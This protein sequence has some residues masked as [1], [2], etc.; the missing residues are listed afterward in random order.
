[1]MD[2]SDRYREAL[3]KSL[4]SDGWEQAFDHGRL[5]EWLAKNEDRLRLNARALLGESDDAHV[6]YCKAIEDFVPKNRYDLPSTE[7][8][9]R[10]IL[11]G[12]IQCAASIGLKPTRD[13]ELVTSTSISPTPFARPTTT[14]HQLFIGLGTSAFCNYWAKAYTAIVKAIAASGPPFEKI[15]EASQLRTHLARDPRALILSAR[16]SLYYAATGTVLG[17]GEV[18]QPRDHFAERMQLL[19]SMEIFAVAHEYAHFL[20][21][22]RGLSFVDETGEPA[23]IGIEYFCDAIGLQISREWGSKN[24]NWFAFAGVG[25][26][27][28]FRAIETCT[29]CANA[30]AMRSAAPVDTAMRSAGNAISHPPA[31]ERALTL[32]KRSIDTTAVDQ[33]KAVESFLGEYDLIC[34]AIGTYVLE[35]V[36]SKDG[37]DRSSGSLP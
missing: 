7:G 10:P 21:D 37:V 2:D 27:A 3:Q 17:F 36:E 8:I 18:E 30:V 14:T 23:P 32:I 13:V 29:N 15:T 34:T 22:E 4:V 9:F 33:R 11:E 16:L 24:D 19:Q 20:A 26:L 35:L 6:A 5:K 31:S 1:M 12:V 28:F 25:G